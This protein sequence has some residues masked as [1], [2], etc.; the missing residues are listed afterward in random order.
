[1]RAKDTILCISP[2]WRMRNDG[3]R[4]LIYKYSN[5]ESEW[6]VLP[7]WEALALSLF[8]GE[9]NLK[10]IAE[11]LA[12]IINYPLESVQK[13]IEKVIVR[14]YHSE[15][16]ILVLKESVQ[17]SDLCIYDPLRIY[18][19]PK[20]YTPIKRLD[21]PLSLL[22]MPSNSCKTDCFYCYADR[23]P[24]KRNAL[25]SVS[26]WKELIDEASDAGVDIASFSGGDPMQYPGIISLMDKLI[27]K[28]FLFSIPTKTYVSPTLALRLV[29]MGFGSRYFQISID[30]WSDKLADLM[31]RRPGYK[32]LAVK[33]I[34]N[35]VKMGIRVRTNT[36]CTH[37][38]CRDIPNLLI[39]L[40]VLGVK[41]SSVAI[42]SR[43]IFRHDDSFFMSKKD[44]IW[45]KK[46]VA[47]IKGRFPN[48]DVSFNG[49][50]IDYNRLSIKNKN[51]QWKARAHCSGGTSS[52]TICADGR[53]ILCEQIPQEDQY[54]AGNVKHQSLLEVWNSYQMRKVAFPPR[55]KFRNTVCYNCKNFN[56]CHYQFGYCFRDSLNA[57]GTIYAPPPNCP[58]A[59]PS[60]RFA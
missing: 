49:T 54:S 15:N 6:S 57:Y 41:R 12:Q 60:P 26:R 10:K 21:A 34:S 23:K 33:S 53:V 22:L 19:S 35:L 25:L 9:T 56:E 37:L 7:P 47:Q 36:V 27:E 2:Q 46:Q 24:V 50:I 13:M 44:I 42:Y 55:E 1:M 20:E 32:D 58:Q 11:H 43:S 18:I 59:P 5:E 51:Q 38:N 48:Y 3:K 52:M 17:E 4:V 45:L 31:V 29:D 28:D 16:P 39:H 40:A 14:R 8:N 30:A